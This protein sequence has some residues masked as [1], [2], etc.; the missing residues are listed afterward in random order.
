MYEKVYKCIEKCSEGHSCPSFQH[1]DI[2]LE[3]KKEMTFFVRHAIYQQF[4]ARQEKKICCFNKILSSFR[5]V[6]IGNETF[7]N[8][9]NRL[10]SWEI[11][12]DYSYGQLCMIPAHVISTTI[13]LF[14]ANGPSFKELLRPVDIVNKLL[15]SPVLIPLE[16]RFADVYIELMCPELN[17]FR[18]N[19]LKSK[20]ENS[21]HIYLQMYASTLN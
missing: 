7:L 16:K 20:L 19:L 8:V 17:I 13:D 10:L 9:L 15:D 11:L 14:L 5:T 1:A 21:P 6:R 4:V 3:T 18:G 2:I 12:R